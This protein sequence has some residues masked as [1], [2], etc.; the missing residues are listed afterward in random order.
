MAV[1][2]AAERG[3]AATT[4]CVH[5]EGSTTDPATMYVSGR[6]Q[7]ISKPEDKVTEFELRVAQELF[8]LEVSYSRRREAGTA[9]RINSGCTR[10]FRGYIERFRGLHDYSWILIREER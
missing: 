8:N 3:W 2:V 4:F 5:G 6:D 1:K 7:K 10:P 9:T